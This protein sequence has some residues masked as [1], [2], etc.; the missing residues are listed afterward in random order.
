VFAAEDIQQ[1]VEKKERCPE[2]SKGDSGKVVYVNKKAEPRSL[3]RVIILELD[4]RTRTP[5][6]P[7]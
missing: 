4:I 1:P 2:R 7:R 6:W 5:Y 3:A